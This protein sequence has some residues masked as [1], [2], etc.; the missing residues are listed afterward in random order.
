M[1]AVGR[2]ASR[3]ATG[4]AIP[5]GDVGAQRN[6]SADRAERVAATVRAGMARG[7]EQPRLAPYR[8]LIVVR[9]FTAVTLG[10]PYAVNCEMV[11]PGT[12]PVSA[13]AVFWVAMVGF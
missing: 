6:S 7:Q 4:Q 8:A 10:N 12:E 11:K 13:G 3:P 1:G 5:A 2:P 9:R